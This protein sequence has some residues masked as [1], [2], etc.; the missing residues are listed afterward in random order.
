MAKT[1]VHVVTASFNFPDAAKVAI[2]RLKEAQSVQ[3]FKLGHAAAL[4]VDDEGKLHII[5][6]ADMGGRKGAVLG[7]TT[8]AVLGILGGPAVWAAAGVGAVVGGLAAKWHDAGL[9]NDKLQALG[10]QLSPGS[11]LLVVE[12]DEQSADAVEKQLRH[13]GAD[14]V[15]EIVDGEVAEEFDALAAKK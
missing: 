6:T 8:G 13:F 3:H 14:V 12:V 5:E 4:G 9:P 11:S 1:P 15:K 10:G 2:K 7:G